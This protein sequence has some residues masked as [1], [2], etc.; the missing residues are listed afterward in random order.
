M[1]ELA[2]GVKIDMMSPRHIGDAVRRVLANDDEIARQRKTLLGMRAFMVRQIAD[3]DA[4]L[5]VAE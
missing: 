1:Y 2:S 4:A 5:G 3:I